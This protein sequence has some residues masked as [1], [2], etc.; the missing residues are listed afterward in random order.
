V[1]IRHYGFE[2]HLKAKKL[3]VLQET[4]QVNCWKLG[5]EAF[6]PNALVKMQQVICIEY[7]FDQRGPPASKF[8]SL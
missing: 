1:K 2:Q 4:L 8:K 6:Y 3:K 7:G 5:E